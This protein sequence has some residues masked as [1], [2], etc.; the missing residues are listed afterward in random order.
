M[1]T[2]PSS[3]HRNE[4][5]FGFLWQTLGATR[6]ST[7]IFIKNGYNRLSMLSL[8]EIWGKKLNHPSS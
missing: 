3:K 5:L 4:R 6:K 1:T 2:G 7:G 8:R